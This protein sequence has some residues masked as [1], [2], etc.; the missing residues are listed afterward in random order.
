MKRYFFLTLA[1][2]VLSLISCSVTDNPSE[3][4]EDNQVSVSFTADLSNGVTKALDDG[5]GAGIHADRC[6]LQVWWGNT[7]F[8]EKTVDVS[9]MTAKF[10]N[11]ILLKDQTY[12]F[13]FWADNKAGTY[14]VTDTLTKVSLKGSYVGGKDE[15]DAFYAAV[16]GKTVSEGFSQTVELHRPF[17]QMNVITTDIPTLYKQFKDPLQF[18]AL[19]PEK[20]GI[21]VTVPTVF[22]VK[23]GVASSPSELA[24]EAPIYTSPLRT[25]DGKK[26][27]LS[28]DYLFAPS[29]EGNVVDVEF[30]AKNETS[31]LSDIR[32]KFTNIPL[33]R[34]Y[35]TNIIGAHL[36]VVGEV[37]VEIVPTWD[38]EIDK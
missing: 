20:I 37:K 30:K 18:A 9:S 27:T 13:L 6:K 16:N 32:N 26:N 1:A 24:Y 35:R 17:A 22:N 3:V 14:Y 25:D 5:D 7:L 4:N 34:N 38:G 33:R 2:A 21:K 12:D 8:F 19:L 31:G 28:M 15:R 10:E 29:T 11:I 23:T 36:T